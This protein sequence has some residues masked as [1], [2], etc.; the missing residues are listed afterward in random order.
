MKI[1]GGIEQYNNSD[2]YILI[3]TK[4]GNRHGKDRVHQYSHR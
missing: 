1:G 4:S 2:C 3:N